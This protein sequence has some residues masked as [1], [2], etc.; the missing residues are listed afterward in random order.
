[1]TPEQTTL[2]NDLATWWTGAATEG[3]APNVVVYTK[4]GNG[5]VV[6]SIAPPSSTNVS[7]SPSAVLFQSL[8]LDVDPSVLRNTFLSQSNSAPVSFI[9]DT[10]KPNAAPNQPNVVTSRYWYVYRKQAATP[11]NSSAASSVLYYNT[12]RLA[13]DLTDPATGLP[14]PIQL[15]QIGGGSGATYSVSSVIVTDSSS[16]NITNDVDIDWARG[17]IYFPESYTFGNATYTTEGQEFR[18]IYSYTNSSGSPLV[19]DTGNVTAVVSWQ[20]EPLFNATSTLGTVG[21]HVLPIST[22][23]NEGEPTAFLDPNAG[24]LNNAGGLALNPSSV[25][26]LAPNGQ[27]YPHKV[28]VFWTSNRNAVTVAHAYDNP[29]SDIYWETIDP[30]F[31]VIN[32]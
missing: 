29:G 23:S 19:T 28:W 12:R 25:T 26:P 32:P 22:P 21:E 13:L 27:P 3:Q 11:T 20:D 2:I 30:R 31:E 10:V 5:T 15:N 16:N 6:F 17:R 14:T 9:D 1:L 7:S 4:P 24:L 18:V 8:N